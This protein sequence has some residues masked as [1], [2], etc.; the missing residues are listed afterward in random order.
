MHRRLNASVAGLFNLEGARHQTMKTPSIASL[1]KVTAENLA[2]LGAD[3]LAEILV[4]VAETRPDLKGRLRM[5]LA[6]EQ[7]PGHLVA[8][9]DKR[10]AA[11]EASRG[12]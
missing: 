7:E 5:E 10:L 8:E 6:V 1:K 9:I 12:R 2:G 3:R 4:G 11:F